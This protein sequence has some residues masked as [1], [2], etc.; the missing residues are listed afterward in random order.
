M[1]SL[2]TLNS[3]FAIAGQLTFRANAEGLIFADIDNAQ[4]SAS[5][6]LQGG[7]V[8][9]WQPKGQARPVVWVSSQAKYAPGKSI[10]GGV[11]VCWPWFGPHETE[12]GFPAHGFARTVPW[13]V[14]AS[15]ALADGAAEIVLTMQETEQ[16]RAQW[17]QP[18]KLEI[19]VSVGATLK[20]ELTTS[21]LGTQAFAIGEALHTYFEI[22][23]IAEIKLH[24]LD[25]CEYL[26]KVANFARKRQDGA[27]VFAGETDRVYLDTEA[28]C[29]IEDAQLKRRIRIA[30]SG[31]RSTVVWT[32]WT[33]KAE[34]MGD[35]GPGISGKGGWREMVCVESAN[36]IDNLVN[37]PAGRA[38]TL[39]VEYSVEPLSA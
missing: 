11:P 36:A 6:C 31:S 34:K 15:R 1:S 14:S 33:E 22:G 30:K 27:I 37:V 29:V 9:S 10:R 39:A 12:A 4:A 25:G 20:V 2:E 21:N 28:E 17:P 18:T 26:D 8:V 19:R 23:D 7:H 5:V 38:H 13:A 24:G 32:P 35:F 3:H 16:T